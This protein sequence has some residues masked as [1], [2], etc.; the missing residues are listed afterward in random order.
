MSRDF[1]E[2]ASL[3]FKR[4]QQPPPGLQSVWDRQRSASSMPSLTSRAGKHTY[5]VATAFALSGLAATEIM[6]HDLGNPG[7]GDAGV[8]RFRSIITSS[9]ALERTEG[10]IADL[11]DTALTALDKIE[12]ANGAGDVLSELVAAAVRRRR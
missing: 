9:G 7:L 10:R 1:F 4:S 6:R 5:L 3:W 8:E 12:L 11:T 2:I